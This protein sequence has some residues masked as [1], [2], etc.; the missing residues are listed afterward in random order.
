V[1]LVPTHASPRTCSR[2]CVQPISK[3]LSRTSALQ[4]QQDIVEDDDRGIRRGRPEGSSRIQQLG[5][6]GSSACRE[7]RTRRSSP[8][9]STASGPALEGRARPTC[10]S[11]PPRSRFA[12]RRPDTENR[13]EGA[14]WSARRKSA[15][16]TG[17]RRI[18]GERLRHVARWCQ[19]RSSSSR[20]RPS[21]A[22]WPRNRPTA[23]CSCRRRW[24][25]STT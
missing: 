8:P 1:D 19:D 25:P 6:Q 22:I 13:R 12:S 23:S 2:S 10:A 24:A 14:A 15:T 3:P 20:I 9:D 7:R 17:K 21:N 4:R 11:K 5:P 18:D 16:V